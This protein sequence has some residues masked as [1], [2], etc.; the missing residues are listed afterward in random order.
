MQPWATSTVNDNASI[1]GNSL[2]LVFV[3]HFLSLHAERALCT[4]LQARKYNYLVTVHEHSKQVI[5]F[6]LVIVHGHNNQFGLDHQPSP[7][8][9]AESSLMWDC[10]RFYWADPDPVSFWAGS[11]PFKK[12]I[13]KKNHLKKI[14]D[15]PAYFSTEF[16]LVL[17]CIFIP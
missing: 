16:C 15:F 10:V 7:Y 5:I 17:V 14:C 1:P 9:W 11:G 8:G 3:S 12:Q 4:F 2:P 13:S 6:G